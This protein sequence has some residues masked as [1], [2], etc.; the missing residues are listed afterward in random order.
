MSDTSVLERYQEYRAERFL[1]RENQYRNWLPNWRTQRRRR[2]L[3]VALA[4]SFTFM[5]AVGVVSH[6]SMT[7]GPMLWLPAIFICLPIW[8]ILQIVS[9]RRGDA[10][11]D[12]LDEWELQQRDSARSI[13]LTITQTITLVPIFYL[14]L[15]GSFGAE[16]PNYPYAGGL[17]VLTTILIGGCTPAMILAWTTPDPEP[18]DST[19]AGSDPADHRV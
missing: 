4:A 19:P 1:H 3:V 7:V 12:V 14:L 6:F 18:D 5:L 11:R 17:L 13:G 16:A 15:A 2:I 9:G 8:T 10:P